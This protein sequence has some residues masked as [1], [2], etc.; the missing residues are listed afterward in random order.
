AAIGSI[1]CIYPLK[2]FKLTDERFLNTLDYID[3]HCMYDGG[4][5]HDVMHSGFGTYLTAHVAQCYVAL[6]DKKALKILN[7]LLDKATDTF[8]WPEAINPQNFGGNMGDG[9]HGWAAADFLLLVR[10]M[11]FYEDEDKLVLLPCV[12][13]DWFKVGEQISVDSAPSYFGT[14][15]FKLKTMRNKVVELKADFNFHRLPEVVEVNLPESIKTLKFRD[16]DYK[17]E[18]GKVLLPK[19]SFEISK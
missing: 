11:L 16:V 13:D 18:D 8:T 6:R 7:W 19:K 1:A 12:P 4:F 10:N 9:H 15:D 3:K 5:F 17:V 14:I 2:V